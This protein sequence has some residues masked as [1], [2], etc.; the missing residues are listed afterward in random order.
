MDGER[1]ERASQR[2]RLRPQVARTRRRS[3]RSGFFGG[4]LPWRGI[5]EGRLGEGGG[6][7][8]R[9]ARRGLR[10]GERRVDVEEP[11]VVTEDTERFGDLMMGLGLGFMVS[12]LGGI[13]AG[14]CIGEK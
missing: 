1:R 11:M 13:L 2:S 14:F 3:W 5:S 12:G 7:E 10:R 6:E 8:P 9:K 4:F